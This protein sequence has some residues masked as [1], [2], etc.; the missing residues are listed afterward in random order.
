[1][2]PKILFIMHMPPP[3]HGAAMM[4]KY[5]HDS[6]LINDTFDCLYINPSAS[7]EVANVGKINL[8]KF[9]FL[10]SNIYKIIKTVLRK[11]P[12]LCYFTSTVGGVGIFRDMIIVGV[13]KLL[14][15]K[16][17]LHLHNKGA[18]KYNQKQPLSII[19]YKIIF[20]NVK[21]IQ[22]SE[23]LYEDIEKFVAKTNIFICPNGIPETLVTEPSVNRNNSVPK[24]LFLSNLLIDKGVFTLLDACK[25]LKDK[26]Y[27]FSCDFVGG[28][29]ID[30]NAERFY[31]EVQVRELTNTVAYRGRKYGK[32]KEAFFNHADIFV[33]PTFYKGE[34]FGLV[35]L[36]AMEHKLPI[37][38]TDEGG[39]PDVVKNG[40]NGFICIKD[41]PDSLA[42]C[43][44]KLLLDKNLR[45]KMGEDGYKK[46]KTYYTLPTFEKN[47]KS[48][49]MQ[50]IKN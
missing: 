50:C 17:V 35:N 11:K 20:S 23:Y 38:S 12:D 14:R 4:G 40:E 1:M 8:K 15:Q 44:E 29:T 39:I 10:F 21:V 32:E 18:K 45:Y 26:G 31:Q 24:L 5:I 19:A 6:K 13:L 42:K 37:V 28:E 43:I 49:L 3:V 7:K 36:E 34:T 22:L 46:F 25:I 2:K 48:I 30:I 27:K 41:N 47:I 33:F 16:I 9:L